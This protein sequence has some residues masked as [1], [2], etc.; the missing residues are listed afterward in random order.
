MLLDIIFET[1][2]KDHLLQEVFSYLLK[3]GECL[4]RVRAQ[5]II[6]S[7]AVAMCFM[8]LTFF[9]PFDFFIKN[10]IEWVFSLQMSRCH[11]DIVTQLIDD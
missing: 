9:S 6:D 8:H 3:F 7:D 11:A 1:L 2:C 10:E 4:L 5:T